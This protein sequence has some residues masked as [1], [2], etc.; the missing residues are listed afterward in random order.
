LLIPYN[1][2][3]RGESGHNHVL[4]R[5]FVCKL[6]LEAAAATGQ[7]RTVILPPETRASQNGGGGPAATKKRALV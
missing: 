6:Q 2:A 3:A 7:R 5:F 1:R 4:K